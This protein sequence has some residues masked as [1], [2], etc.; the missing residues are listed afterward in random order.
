MWNGGIGCLRTRKRR[1]EVTWPTKEEKSS[2]ILKLEDVVSIVK[3]RK[4][5]LQIK[6]EDGGKAIK[7]EGR[8]SMH[9]DC[10]YWRNNWDE[11]IVIV[12]R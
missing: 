4:A 1:R 2:K 9:I 10:R 7:T 5:K 3:E 11:L 8:H 12:C 6:K